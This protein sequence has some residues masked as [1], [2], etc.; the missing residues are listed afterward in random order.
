M[1]S[2]NGSMFSLHFATMVQ[3]SHPRRGIALLEVMIA[4][5]LLTLAVSAIT[6][7]IVASQQQNLEARERIVASISAESLLSQIGEQPWET[8]DSWD[9]F[10]EDPGTLT[11]PTGVLL[12]GDW[13]HIG[14]T[15]GVTFTE[16]FIDELQIYI[17]GKTINVIVF[18]ANA[19]ELANL[20]RFIAEPS[21]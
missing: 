4:V 11:D 9:G 13:E 2:I 18:N 16:V 17:R 3:Q 10:T 7:S 14:R 6:Q 8:L 1:F 12:M 19:R 5:G 20:E 15:V 21:P